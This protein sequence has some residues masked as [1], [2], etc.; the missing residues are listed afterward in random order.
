MTSCIFHAI[1]LLKA[2]D[3]KAG[4]LNDRGIDDY[5]KIERDSAITSPPQGRSMLRPRHN[6][7]RARKIANGLVSQLFTIDDGSLPEVHTEHDQVI[8]DP[9]RLFRFMLDVFQL[10]EKALRGELM[11]ALTGDGAAVCTSTN[12]A[13]QSLFGFKLIDEN[14]INPLTGL[15]LLCTVIEDEDGASRKSFRGAQSNVCCMVATAVMAKEKEAMQSDGFKGLVSFAKKLESDGIPA[16]GDEVAI[17]AQKGGLVCCGDLSF[18]QKVSDRGGACKVK[19]FFCTYCAT[20]S[21]SHDLLAY[22]TGDEICPMCVRNVKTKCAHVAVDDTTELERKGVDLMTMLLVDFRSTKSLPLANMRDMLPAEPVECFFWI[23][24][25]RE[26][27]GTMLFA[28]A[29]FG[30]WNSVPPSSPV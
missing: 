25:R 27:D 18:H 13:S 29:C 23:H 20:E 26:G 28:G 19:Q 3:I 24:R 8:F 10:K 30:R 22:V 6:V 11:S 12:T 5:S 14:A 9:E 2:I 17:P 16:N 4:S 15:P 21:G 1:V 7:T